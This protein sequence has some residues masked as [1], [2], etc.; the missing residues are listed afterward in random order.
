GPHAGGP[1]FLVPVKGIEPSTF[2]LRLQNHSLAFGR[3][4][5]TAAVKRS[6]VEVVS[7]GALLG[8]IH[9]DIINNNETSAIPR[10]LAQVPARVSERRTARCWSPARPRTARQATG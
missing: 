8:Y 7:F 9:T 3:L 2:A 1:M 5:E 4:G 10:R 6:S